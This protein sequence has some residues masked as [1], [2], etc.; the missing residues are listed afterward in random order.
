MAWI[1]IVKEWFLSCTFWILWSWRR[2]RGSKQ[3]LQSYSLPS[4]CTLLCWL[5]PV[6]RFKLSGSRFSSCNSPPPSPYSEKGMEE[7]WPDFSQIQHFIAIYLRLNC[8]GWNAIWK[9]TSTFQLYTKWQQ[10]KLKLIQV[11]SALKIKS[12]QPN[13][14]LYHLENNTFL[15]EFCFCVCVV[16]VFGVV[17]TLI[18]PSANAIRGTEHEHCN[19]LFLASTEAPQP[20]SFSWFYHFMNSHNHGYRGVRGLRNCTIYNT[21]I[22]SDKA[23]KSEDTKNLK[24]LLLLH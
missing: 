8:A 15:V 3:P 22:S 18:N 24:K 17:V 11:R 21:W 7:N 1:Q 4:G 20:C 19:V 23:I 14:F 2:W 6:T 13:P 10:C 9:V 16:C 12:H 5:R